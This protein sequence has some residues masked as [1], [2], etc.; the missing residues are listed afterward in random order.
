MKKAEEVQAPHK[1]WKMTRERMKTAGK[2]GIV[3]VTVWVSDPKGLEAETK[4]V[5]ERSAA[6]S[7]A[8]NVNVA[9]TTEAAEPHP[10]VWIVHS[11]ALAFVT[12]CSSASVPVPRDVTLSPTLADTDAG[13]T[14]TVTGP[15][16]LTSIVG[17]TRVHVWDAESATVREIGRASC[18]ERG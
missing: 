9:P 13:A 18:R 3:T 15:P 14:V 1:N 7:G 4:I 11:I 10:S 2:A 12:S 17:R 6:P 16:W 8:R 5:Q